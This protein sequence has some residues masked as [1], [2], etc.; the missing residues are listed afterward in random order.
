MSQKVFFL[1]YEI[2]QMP[3]FKLSEVLLSNKICM[4][5]NMKQEKNPNA[6]KV[7][8]LSTEFCTLHSLSSHLLPTKSAKSNMF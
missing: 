5:R 6:I 8:K 2:M 4:V 1:K 3:V 7:F